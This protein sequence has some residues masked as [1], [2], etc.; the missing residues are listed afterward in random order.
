MVIKI[1]VKIF[2]GKL[3]IANFLFCHVC[4]YL[5]R[6]G[7]TWVY[8]IIVVVYGL[9]GWF[10]KPIWGDALVQRFIF[11]NHLCQKRI[12]CEIG[13]SFDVAQGSGYR[14]LVESNRY[15][16]LYSFLSLHSCYSLIVLFLSS[17]LFVL[18]EVFIKKGFS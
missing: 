6:S 10:I 9:C 16:S 13:K 5:I 2:Y 3:F 17:L 14:H 15:K 4:L 8:G 12:Y 1:K 11:P 7:K 18:A